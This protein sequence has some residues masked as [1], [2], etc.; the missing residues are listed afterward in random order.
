MRNR[1][2]NQKMPL[3]VALSFCLLMALVSVAEAQQCNTSP[4]VVDLKTGAI[5]GSNSRI[6]FPIPPTNSSAYPSWKEAVA[7][8]HAG[9][10]CRCVNVALEYEGASTAWTLNIGDSPT[11]DGYGGDAGSPDSEAEMQIVNDDMA[12]YSSALAPGVVDNLLR[13]RLAL[14]NGAVKFVVCDQYLSFGNPNGILTT[15]NLKKLFAMPDSGVGNSDIFVGL[16][17]V[18]SG[19]GSRHGKGLR[20]A[21]ISLQ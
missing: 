16:N 10:G 9:D 11:N 18:I 20:R 5:G 14:T 1:I 19:P 12:V 4:V 2:F 6:A 21:T 8:I 17:R 15:P 3:L 13:Q 7:Q